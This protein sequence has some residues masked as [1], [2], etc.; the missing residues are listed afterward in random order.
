[1]FSLQSYAIAGLLVFG[2]AGYGLL[3]LK[4][5]GAISNLETA[6]K[7]KIETAVKTTHD[8]AE[9]QCRKNI[10][11]LKQ[12]YTGAAD[13]EVSS[14]TAAAAGVPP[15][16]KEQKLIMCKADKNCRSHNRLNA[17][18]PEVPDQP[19]TNGVSFE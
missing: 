16:T 10:A 1:M 12:E 9:S 8:E 6:H 5:A 2:V 14:G 11:D 4:H 15:V 7:T 18:P 17:A 19:T 13:D 3:E